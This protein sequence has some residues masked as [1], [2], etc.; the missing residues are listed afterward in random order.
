[1]K[2]NYSAKLIISVIFFICAMNNMKAQMVYLPDTNFRN[3]L[4]N[5]GYGTC[6]VGDSINSSCLLVVNTTSLSVSNANIHSLQGIQAFGNLISLQC[7]YDSLITLPIL[8][9]S[10]Q[11]L[12]CNNNKISGIT[13]LPNSLVHFS[14]NNNQLTTLPSLPN[15]ITSFICYSNQLTNLP[16]LPP[17]L[18]D[19]RCYQNQLTTLPSLPGTIYQIDCSNNLLTTLPSLPNSLRFLTCSINQISSLPSLPNELKALSC[20]NNLIDTLSEMPDSLIILDCSANPLH[21]LPLLN[22]S[23]KSLECS[24]DSLVSLPTLP[25][26]LVSLICSVNQ[27]SSLPSLTSNLVHLECSSNPLFNLPSLPNSLRELYCANNNLTSL[28][29]LPNSLTWLECQSNQLIAFP[30]FPDSMELIDCYNNLTLHCLPRIKII[31]TFFHQNTGIN[32][33]PNYGQIALSYPPLT[34]M[35]LCGL[36]NFYGCQFFWNISGR[37]YFD[38]DINCSY[39]PIDIGQENMKIDLYRNGNLIQQT[40]A[41]QGGNYSFKTDSLGIY[42]TRLD[43][44]YTPFT[45]LCPLN[46]SNSDTLTTADSLKYDRNFGLKCKVGFDLGVHSIGG[47]PFRPAHNTTV[48]LQVG[49]ISSFYGS[50]CAAG[51]SGSITVTLN[52]SISYVGPAAGALTPNN[53]SASTLTYN[54]ADFGTVNFNSDFNIIVATDTFAVIGS[55]ACITVSVLPV[56]GDYNPS[57]NTLTHCFTIVGSYDPNEKEVDPVSTI[58]LTGNK[59]L[60]YTIH[61]QNTGT[62]TAEHIYITDTLNSN[63]DLSTFQLLA[64]SHQP[65]VQILE[66]GIARFNFP[67]INLPDSNTNEPASHGYI[68]YKIKVKDNATVGTQI[69]NTAYIYFDFNTPVVTNTTI[70]TVTNSV[71]ITNLNNDLEVSIF[72]NPTH[73]E[74]TVYCSQFTPGKKVLLKV[75]DAFGKEISRQ[76]ATT[77]N[78]KL[79]TVNWS[80]GIYFLCIETTEDVAV[81]KLVKE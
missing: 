10:I 8:P 59:W 63:L 32:C 73:S 46:G 67:N 75:V 66:G 49:D 5:L 48:L 30:E 60:T 51:I 58:D 44:T 17:T 70:N 16:T 53:V 1:M 64:Y 7:A 4:V 11:N 25:I 13:L 15:S 40:I 54:V 18:Y 71:G 33:F 76:V 43:T 24:A 42:E 20:N 78:T 41:T 72:P 12:S 23:L 29:A 34:N 61:F 80:S 26:K 27:I 36:F 74:F 21:N 19:F 65:L 50:H 47:F 62:A 6:I 69:S 39:D 52:G 77:A 2:K 3:K 68:Q 81:K 28:P 9:N 31:N 14:C 57:N 35:P 79:E 45:F 22:D 55:Q 37:V 56:A 38:A